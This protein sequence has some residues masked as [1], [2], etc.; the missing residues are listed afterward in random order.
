MMKRTS[1]TTTG[2][3]GGFTLI[4]VLVVLGILVLL[5][6]MVGPRILG[7]RDK[8]DINATKTQISNFKGALKLY[9]LDMRTYPSTEEGLAAIIEEPAS[10]DE[11][12]SK[13][14][15]PY[16]EAEDMPADPWGNDFQYAYP[17]E[18]GKG[19]QPDIWS[20]GP[21]G[22]DGTDDDIT[23]WKKSSED[24]EESFDDAGDDE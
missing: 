22:E 23:S 6:T 15:G 9:R 21:D 8:A 14:G 16:L 19:D 12:D 17:P 4:E 13:W 10:E 2:H 1:Q 11:G 20:M 24:G 3:R 7:S 5:A 18:N